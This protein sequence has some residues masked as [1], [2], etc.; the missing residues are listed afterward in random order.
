MSTIRKLQPHLAPP[1]AQIQKPKTLEE[2][3]GEA[4]KVLDDYADF[5]DDANE[6]GN[7]PQNSSTENN[8]DEDSVLGFEVEMKD[9]EVILFAAAE[10]SNTNEDVESK[11][12]KTLAY[13]P[14][15]DLKGGEQVS[16]QD[17]L[18]ALSRPE[19]DIVEWLHC[20]RIAI[21]KLGQLHVP[22]WVQAVDEWQKQHAKA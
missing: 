11:A 20:M 7:T 14:P 6:T 4:W 8:D 12:E 10:I 2:I 9:G 18:A 3:Q 16:A 15:T 22:M 13:Y 5:E 21:Q 1:S 17:C 19:R